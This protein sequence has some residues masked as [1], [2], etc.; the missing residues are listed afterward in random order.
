LSYWNAVLKGVLGDPVAI[1]IGKGP[2]TSIELIFGELGARAWAH[3]DFVDLFATGGLILLGSYLALLAWMF[4]SAIRLWRDPR[5]SRV[6]RDV[7]A[8]GVIT[9]AAFIVLSLFNGVLFA[10]ASIAVA[11]LIGLIRGMRATPGT[12]WADSAGEPVPHQ[13]SPRA[14]P[15]VASG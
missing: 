5:H 7:G 10:P 8:V 13:A 6:A 1:L 11:L 4:A 9:C 2:D 14:R 15:A 3:N 12:T